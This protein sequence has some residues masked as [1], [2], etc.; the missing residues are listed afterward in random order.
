MLAS[1]LSSDRAIEASIIVVRAF[2][3]LRRAVIGYADL[4]S[5]VEQLEALGVSHDEQLSAIIA[6]LNELI[7]SP[8][9]PERQFGFR[10]HDD[11]R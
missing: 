2:I 3:H 10:S 1:V 5:R 9:E 4:L 11:E 6:A 7:R 8:E